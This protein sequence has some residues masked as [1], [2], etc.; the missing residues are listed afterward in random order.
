[1]TM[2]TNCE[3]CGQPAV[4]VSERERMADALRRAYLVATNGGV[5]LGWTTLS[6][7]VRRAWLAEADAALAFNAK[8]VAKLEAK[9]E[10][11]E[12]ESQRRDANEAAACHRAFE[13]IA[14]A[15]GADTVGGSFPE[16]VYRA[17]NHLRTALEVEKLTANRRGVE[18]DEAR[19]EVA[20][21]KVGFGLAASEREAVVTTWMKRHEGAL[22]QDTTWAL[23]NL[24]CD[25]L[26]AV[27]DVANGKPLGI[28]AERAKPAANPHLVDSLLRDIEPPNPAPTLPKPWSW[29]WSH[30]LNRWAKVYLCSCPLFCVVGDVMAYSLNGHGITWTDARPERRPKVGDKVWVRFSWMPKAVLC[31]VQPTQTHGYRTFFCEKGAGWNYECEFDDHGVTWWFED[32][33]PRS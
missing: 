18:R 5:P 21:L 32:E 24:A 1:M 30:R 23:N 2:T 9:L 11:A 27:V 29:V 33:R 17:F 10:E 22:K 25:I 3:K 16:C 15:T 4:E 12:K 26:R 31:P 8:R 13:E 20:R 7:H 14:Q 28:D 19:A 6:E